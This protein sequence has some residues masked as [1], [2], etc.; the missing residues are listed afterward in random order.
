MPDTPEQRTHFG[1]QVHVKV[2]SSYPEELAMALAHVA[3]H[4]IRR[5]ASGPCGTNEMQYARALPPSISDHSQT[6]LDKS[7]M[8]A[9]IGCQLRNNGN[10]RH[11]IIPAKSNT[12]RRPLALAG[13]MC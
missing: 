1:A 5:A 8:S 10:N 7:F 3:A 12:T 13:W 9:E 6:A 11:F 2:V 4:L